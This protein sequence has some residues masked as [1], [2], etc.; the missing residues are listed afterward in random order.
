M[1]THK[2]SIIGLTETWLNDMEGDN[3]KIPGYNLT[4][5]TSKIKV[6]GELVFLLGKIL[7]SNYEMI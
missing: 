5:V 1:L 2:F 3:F 6:E 4:K 7:K